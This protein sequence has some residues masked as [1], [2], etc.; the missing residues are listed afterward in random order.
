M[1]IL[2]KKE[3]FE[4]LY[5]MPIS[6]GILL[7]NDKR[8]L[9]ILKPTYREGYLI[10]GGGIEK[11]ESPKEGL[12]REIREEIGLDLEIGEILC[13]NYYPNNEM[14]FD[15]AEIQLI[16]YGGVL[17]QNEINSIVLN[18]EEHHSFCFVPLDEALSL[19]N[20]YLSKTIA[21]CMKAL[22]REKTFYLEKGEM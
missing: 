5:K 20:P 10:P 11:N 16:F 21:S 2:P 7:F 1:K 9:L 14:D 13:F 4:S 8:E 18:P 22:E 3:Y 17:S 12:K 19:V 15:N 6:A